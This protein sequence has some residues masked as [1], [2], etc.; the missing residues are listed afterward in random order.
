[1]FLH[2][3]GSMGHI[4]HYISSRRQTSTHYCSCS[5]GTSTDLTKGV[6][7]HVTPHVFLRLVGSMGHVVH[8]GA[9]G[10]RNIIEL[11]FMLR[12][13]RYGFLKKHVGTNYANLCFCIWFDLWVM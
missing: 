8:S 10:P 4:V 13:A 9:S 3:V 2:L 6:L 11:F 7:R 12:L 1:V 5:S